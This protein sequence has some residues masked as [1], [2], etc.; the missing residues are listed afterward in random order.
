MSEVEQRFQQ[1]GRDVQAWVSRLSISM[2]I[3]S[4]QTEG[5]TREMFNRL[6]DVIEQLTETIKTENSTEDVHAILSSGETREFFDVRTKR[7]NIITD[8]EIDNQEDRE[9]FE[10]A[11]SIVNELFECVKDMVQYTWIMQSCSRT[12]GTT[13]R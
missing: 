11:S 9:N 2:M 5:W 1:R 6:Q 12:K 7:F 3:P 8:G 10:E 13:S 4:D